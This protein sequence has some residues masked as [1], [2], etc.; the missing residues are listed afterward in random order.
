MVTSA[1]IIMLTRPKENGYMKTDLMGQIEAIEQGRPYSYWPNE[2][3]RML[4]QQQQENNNATR[5]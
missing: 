5:K 2:R 3:R 1:K 4:Y